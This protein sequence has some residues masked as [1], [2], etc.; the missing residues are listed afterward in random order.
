[1]SNMFDWCKN[2]EL[3]GGC[4]IGGEGPLMLDQTCGDGPHVTPIERA[5]E[6]QGFLNELSKGIP[7]AATLDT[8]SDHPYQCKCPT[9]LQWWRMMGPDPDDDSYGPFTKEE[10]EECES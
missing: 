1:M 10:I 6:L 2:C 7:N 8:G 9:C 3:V 4:Y 5:P